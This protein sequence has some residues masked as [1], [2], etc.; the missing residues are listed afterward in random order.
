M[1]PKA[2]SPSSPLHAVSHHSPASTA[3]PRPANESTQSNALVLPLPL[4]LISQLKN[5]SPQDLRLQNFLR[6]L[7]YPTYPIY[8][9][10]LRLQSSCRCRLLSS[11]LPLYQGKTLG[12]PPAYSCCELTPDFLAC[13]PVCLSFFFCFASSSLD[14]TTLFCFPSPVFTKAGTDC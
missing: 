14:I 11:P 9:F 8:I 7:R 4:P 6:S 13:L 3:S 2:L 12:Y 10:F 5:L 1:H